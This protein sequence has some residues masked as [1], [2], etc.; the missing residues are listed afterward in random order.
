M[1]I[2]PAKLAWPWLS[3]EEVRE[4]VQHYIDI[5]RIVIATEEELERISRGDFMRVGTWTV[6]T[7]CNKPY[8]NHPYLDS[9]PDLHRLCNGILGKT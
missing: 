7:I 9:D 6:C 5:G 2:E 1:N 3:D 8:V 4:R